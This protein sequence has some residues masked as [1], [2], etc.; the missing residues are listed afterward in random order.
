M[1][2]YQVGKKRAE[3]PGF[4]TINSDSDNGRPTQAKV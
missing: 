1:E 4:E 3:S 2:Y